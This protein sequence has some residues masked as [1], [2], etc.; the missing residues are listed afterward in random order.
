VTR[1]L[2]LA[3]GRRES[4]LESRSFVFFNDAGLRVLSRRRG[5]RT[6]TD[7]SLRRVDALW[8]NHRV[9]GECDGAVKYDIDAA[10]T[11]L[12][13]EKRRQELLEDLGYIVVPGITPTSRTMQPRQDS[14]FCVPSAVLTYYDDGFSPSADAVPP[15][16]RDH[17]RHDPLRAG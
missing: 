1:A 5:S 3:D 16:R 10:P 4:P 8:R 9:I 11:M 15:P 17:P 2:F 7:S 13:A 6:R 12:L 14:G